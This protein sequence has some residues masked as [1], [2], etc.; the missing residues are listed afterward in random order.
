MEPQRHKYPPMLGPL[1]DVAAGT[2]EWAERLGLRI[3][4]GVERIEE[5]GIERLIPWIEMALNTNPAPW[6]TWPLERPCLTPDG[7]F[8]YAASID[9]ASLS[10]LVAAYKGD[11]DLLVRRLQRATAEGERQIADQNKRGGVDLRSDATKV[12]DRGSGY[13]LRRLAR[14]APDTLAQYEQGDF[15]TPTAAARAAGF[16]V[17]AS[18]LQKLYRSWKRATADE[19]AAFLDQIGACLRDEGE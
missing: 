5:Q 7:Y 13:W 12:G 10:K 6:Q 1:E 2:P 8:R 18:E 14:E 11:N 15:P 17:S 4:H 9:C 16:K 19:R 3:M